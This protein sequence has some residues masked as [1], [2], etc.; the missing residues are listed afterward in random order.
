M[1]PPV[2]DRPD[3]LIDLNRRRFLTGLAACPLAAVSLPTVAS[4]ASDLEISVRQNGQEVTTVSP[5]TTDRSIEDFYRYDRIDNASANTPMN[6]RESDVTKLFFYR[7]SG[8]DTP[9]SL[10]IIHDAPHDGNGGGVRFAFQ[11]NALPSGGGWAVEDDPGERFTGMVADWGWAP[12]CTDGGAYRGGFEEGVEVTIDPTFESG[13]RRWD[14]LDGDGSV[15]AELSR[16][17][18]VTLAVASATSGADLEALVAD[19]L[20]LAGRIDTNSL[21]LMNDRAHIEPVLDDLVEAAEAEDGPSRSKVIEAIQRLLA[22]ERF[23][24][25][26]LAGAGPGVSPHLDPDTNISELTARFAVNPML[27]LVFAGISLLKAARVIPGLGGLVDD[28]ARWLGNAVADIAGIFS[29]T[30]ERL[31]RARAREAGLGLF[32]AAEART[33]EEGK[34]LAEEEFRQLREAEGAPFIE[35]STNVIFQDML[36]NEDRDWMGIETDP[37]DESLAELVDNLDAEE[38]ELHGD[39]ER[40]LEAA[41]EG[42]SDLN[43]DYQALDDQLT[44]SLFALFL[45]HVGVLEGILVAVAVVASVTGVLAAAAPVAAAGAALVGLGVGVLGSLIQWGVGANG[46][47]EQRYNHQLLVDDILTPGGG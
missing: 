20:T 11:P 39:T 38:F 12:C 29:D 45:R 26:V 1:T 4:A 19:K 40:A 3:G 18:P 17:A 23:T 14:L 25:A 6:L 32:E 46:I 16:T 8:T 27:E 21:G 7:R 43:E 9:L 44:D 22:G 37:L 5:I 34:R 31:I 15:A 24:D 33:A 42:L 35:E 28:A 47:L 41:A 36:F 10:V 2:S 13:I 30:L